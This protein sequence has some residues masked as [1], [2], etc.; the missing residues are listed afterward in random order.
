MEVKTNATLERMG[1]LRRRSLKLT[2]ENTP[3]ILH[4]ILSVLSIEHQINMNAF[5]STEVVDEFG[6]NIVMFEIGIDD[7]KF[8]RDKFVSDLQE[9]GCSVEFIQ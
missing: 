6:K 3:G 2:V 8:D 4:T 9:L 5:D 7:T 1:N